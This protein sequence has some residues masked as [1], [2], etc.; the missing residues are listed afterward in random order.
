DSG[1]VPEAGR[2]GA[3]VN[4]GARDGVHEL[5]R[6]RAARD[7]DGRAYRGPPG[8]SLV[9]RLRRNP[10]RA[11]R[12]DQDPGSRAASAQHR[13]RRE[14]RC[15]GR[16]RQGGAPR[17]RPRRG[18]AARR[19]HARDLRPEFPDALRDP[20]EGLDPQPLPRGGQGRRRAGRA[21][22]MS[23]GRWLFGRPLA[24]AEEGEQRV[25]PWTG[26]PM[27]GLDALS[28]AAYGPEAAMTLLIP[29][30]LAGVAYVWPI[31]LVIIAL[32]IVVYLSYRQ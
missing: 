23:L 16:A 15:D 30:G 18:R 2:A 8:R 20:D 13:P 27:L 32:L 11:A 26:I 28:S 29:L 7:S 9:R 5:E 24:S 6:Q 17:G 19:H 4:P 12:A 1:V 14:P 25:G 31:S 21:A 22:V 3:G 10:G